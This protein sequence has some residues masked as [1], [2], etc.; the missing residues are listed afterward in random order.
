MKILSIL[1]INIVM[2]ILII[3]QVFF[4]D[5]YYQ[6]KYNDERNNDKLEYLNM[7]SYNSILQSIENVNADIDETTYHWIQS[8]LN[9][10]E[11]NFDKP[12][13]VFKY[14]IHSCTSC[15]DI[16]F[17]TMESTLG[18]ELNDVKQMFFLVSDS[19]PTL[20]GKILQTVNL[21]TK[22]LGIPMEREE[23]PFLFILDKGKIKNIFIPDAN[24]PE[25]TKFYLKVVKEKLF[26][27]DM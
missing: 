7:Y 3:F 1:L 4:K 25:Y 26:R 24:L 22:K 21:G 19:N 27:G 11:M 9:P 10:S 5:I 17:D 18:S 12:I 15:V 23:I 14:S 2:L 8:K 6:D 20:K 13:L 16:V